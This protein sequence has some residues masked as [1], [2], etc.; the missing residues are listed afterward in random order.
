MIPKTSTEKQKMKADT[1]EVESRQIL[2]NRKNLNPK[3]TRTIF[4]V[5]EL[6]NLIL[7]KC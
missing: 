1:H 5:Y 6:E 7:F 4:Y 3:Q 2:K